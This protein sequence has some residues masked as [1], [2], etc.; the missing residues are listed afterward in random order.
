MSKILFTNTNCSFNKGSA[1]QVLSTCKLLRELIPDLQITLLSHFPENDFKL[2][3]ANGIKVVNAYWCP[4]HG[5]MNYRIPRFLIQ[6][7]LNIL[8][9]IFFNLGF[10]S[11]YVENPIIREYL[12][13]DAIID[14]S[15]DSFSDSKGG[16][17]IIVVGSILVGISLKKP[18]ILYSQS[19]GPFNWLTTPLA[20]YCLNNV[21]III[22]REEIT[23]ALLE[24]LGIKSPIYVTA[25]CAFLLDPVPYDRVKE[26]LLNEGIGNIGKPL[27]GIS[28][29]CMLDDK[30]NRYA[31]TMAQ[32]IDYLVDHY[33]AYI[34]LVP[35][36]VSPKQDGIRDDRVIGEKIKKISKYPNNIYLISGDYH[37]GELKGIIR[38]C[39]IFIG[40]RMHANIAAVSMC[41][42]TIATAWSH[43]YLGIMKALALENYV[44]DHTTMT[45]DELISK[46]DE[47][48]NNK[49]KTHN[50][51]KLRVEEQKR[52]A[53]NSG[54]LVR[55]ILDR[56]T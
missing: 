36:V 22:I 43:K 55:E 52:L 24:E 19:I 41:I 51:L 6:N 48:W 25:D 30:K 23:R 34:I 56:V 10:D 5:I 3:E 14:L 32:L 35:H 9:S 50:E 49:I 17:S 2:C 4:C 18:I 37:P 42:P 54:E 28:V 8:Y 29:N 33:K 31:S 13:A 53:R 26:L 20:K 7:S 16:I 1:A 39:D 12:S 46:V 38:C 27:V 45:F 40:G 11:R 21:S 47:L 15:G 44:C